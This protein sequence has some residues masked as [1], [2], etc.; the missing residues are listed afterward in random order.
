MAG[1]G[2][3]GGDEGIDGWMRRLSD[4]DRSAFT[5]VYAE[6]RPLLERFI[7]RALGG[8][9]DVEDAAQQALLNVFARAREYQPERSAKAWM[10]GI[11]AYECRTARKRQGRRR[12]APLAG[13]A[14]ELPA[15]APTPE[16][17]SLSAD[18]EAAAREV[19]GA[20]RPQDR[21]AILASVDDGAASRAGMAPATFRKRL[22]RALQ[23]ARLIW[24][25][26]H[27]EE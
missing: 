17:R 7:R 20:L 22:Q 14:L 3:P 19:L 10:L 1:S 12:E 8:G 21:D 18:L 15:G 26:R 27:G 11:A 25:A 23:R 4:G 16:E 9:P 5:S 2:E 24:R 6:A 13:A